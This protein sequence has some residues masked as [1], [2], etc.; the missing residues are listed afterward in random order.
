MKNGEL[1]AYPLHPEHDSKY[2]AW[3]GL[4]KRE[5]I[6]AMAMQG[7]LSGQAIYDGWGNEKDLAKRAVLIA[8]ALLAELE[9]A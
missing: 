3:E 2:Y 4:T 9:K 1:P 7:E 5:H 8:D 6:A